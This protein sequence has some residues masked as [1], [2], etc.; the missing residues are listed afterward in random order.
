[1]FDQHRERLSRL[2]MQRQGALEEASWKEALDHSAA[3]LALLN[4]KHGPES[5][6]LVG[7]AW[8]TSE[9]TCIF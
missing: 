4:E 2:L 8:Y 1:M 3:Q 5:L 6:A 9:E 7:S